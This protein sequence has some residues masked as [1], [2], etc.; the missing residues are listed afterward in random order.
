M[1]FTK[2]PDMSYTDMCIFF[3]NNFYS[4]DRDDELCFKYMYLVYYML[5]F[6]KHYLQNYNE[7]DEFAE[8]AT[9]TIYTRYLKK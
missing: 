8:Y 6:K 3:D 9:I 1:L 4:E 7:Y 2:D 5:A